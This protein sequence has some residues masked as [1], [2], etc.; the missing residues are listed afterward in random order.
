[1]NHISPN[2]YQEEA[3]RTASGMDYS[4]CPQIVNACLGMAGESGEVSDLVKK[5]IFQGHALDR[6]HFIKELGDVQWYIA[7]AAHCVDA[8]LEE[9]MLANVEKLQKR[10]PNGFEAERSIHRKTGDI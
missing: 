8:T 1:M 3:M 2:E 5:H 10:Y 9:V 4:K 6:E 7:L